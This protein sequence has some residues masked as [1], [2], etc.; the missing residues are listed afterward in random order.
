MIAKPLALCAQMGMDTC[1]VV[2]SGALST[3][4]AV[5]LNGQLAPER[6]RLIPVG[7]WHISEYLKEAMQWQPEDC[8]KVSNVW[9][10]FDI[11]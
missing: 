1:V 2:D 5:I 4:V 6:W 9:Q 3:S 10:A 11:Y 7:G 8:R